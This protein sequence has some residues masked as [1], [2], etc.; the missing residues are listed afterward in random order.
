M[1][2]YSQMVQKKMFR[3]QERRGG[4]RRGD[5]MWLI[6]DLR[7]TEVIWLL[8]WIKWKAIGA[9]KLRNDMM[10]YIYI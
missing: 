6:G 7:V 5:L 9:S 4:K 2:N 3:R 1:P 8:L 10:S